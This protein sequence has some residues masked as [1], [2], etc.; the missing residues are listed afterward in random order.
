MLPWH[1]VAVK[2]VLLPSQVSKLHVGLFTHVGCPAQVPVQQQ[3][4]DGSQVVPSGLQ[5]GVRL[6][7]GEPAQVG[8]RVQVDCVP[9]V[10]RPNWPQ[11]VVPSHVTQPGIVSVQQVG[12]PG[13]V[14]LPEQVLKPV[15]E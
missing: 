3:V 7:V 8:K 2:H 11:V 9:Q 5:V 13:Q 4:G 6:H 14:E 15:H 10:G 1:V 12:L